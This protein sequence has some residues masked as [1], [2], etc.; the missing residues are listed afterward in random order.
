MNLLFVCTGNT[1]RSPLAEVI[2]Q[3]EAENRGLIEV[4]VASAGT[5]AFPGSPAAGPGVAV[6]AA[7]ELDLGDHSAQ[8]VSLELV[9]WADHII[10]MD[11]S[12][13][14]MVQRHVPDA[15][16]HVMTDYLPANHALR[17]QGV[18]D[19]IGG[20]LETYEATYETLRMAIRGFLDA[21]TPE[22]GSDA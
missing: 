4:G 16:V 22:S 21:L 7:H 17:G 14:E 9:E 6:A 19:P 20:D 3:S 1:C 10:G 13:A 2:A 5:F 18:P 12:H 8:E 15:N 11:R